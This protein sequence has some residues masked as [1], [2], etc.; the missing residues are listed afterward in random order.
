MTDMTVRMAVPAIGSRVRISGPRLL[1]AGLWTVY[2][3]VIGAWL[4]FPI[5]LVVVASL[6]GKLEVSWPLSHLNLD[7]YRAIPSGYWQSFW[8]TIRV[9]IVAS[10]CSLLI[11]LPAAWAM[12]RGRLW[13]RRLISSLVLLPEIVPQLILGIALLTIFIPLGLSNSFGGV[14]LALIALNLAMGLRF[15]EAL[16]EGLPEEYE[17]AAESLGASKLAA[18]RLIVLPLIAPGLAIAALFVFMQNLIAFVLLFFIAGPSATPISIR[19]FTDI[20]D[21]GVV[22]EAVAMSAM[23]VYVALIFYAIVALALGPKYMAGALMSR[24]G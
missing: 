19:L 11:S 20:V 5:L 17:L 18:L 10:C 23:L 14:V 12:V 7:A 1:S 16:L 24:K 4:L 9:S 13:E 8:F 2:L 22:P 3:L 6:Q 15:G 21:R